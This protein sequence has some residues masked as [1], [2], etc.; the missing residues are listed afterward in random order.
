MEYLEFT[1]K[2][3]EEALSNA[4]INLG[5]SSDQLDYT[6]I[7]EPSAGFLGLFNAKPAKI[8]VAKKQSVEDVVK[9][10][11]N[12]VFGA[13]DMTVNIEVSV[14]EEEETVNINLIGDDMGL[15]IGK[16]GQTLDSLQYL[17]RLVV[18]KEFGGY[19][20]VKLDTENY[21]E[22][23]KETLESLAKNIAYKVKRT[24]KSVSLEPMNP[25]ERR[26]IHS[27]LQNDKFVSTRSEGEEPFRHVVVFLKK[28]HYNN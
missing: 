23:R 15:L 13:M 22:R 21:R 11:L 5:I 20:K 1:G 4:A 10:F 18:N 24:R 26:I 27:T 9:K 6:V 16:R 19:L 2:T 7:E 3:V 8:K 17:I 25:Y 14:N 12:D 28:Q